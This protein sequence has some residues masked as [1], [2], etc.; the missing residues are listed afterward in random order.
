MNLELRDHVTSVAFHLSLSQRMVA[1]LVFLNEVCEH[2]LPLY[3]RDAGGPFTK[4]LEQWVSP[5]KSLI[6]R[7]L[8][9]HHFDKDH[10]GDRPDSGLRWHYSIT[11][12][13]ELVVGLLREAGIYTD[14]LRAMPGLR[15][16]RAG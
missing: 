12:A 7:G 3:G 10:A 14:V 15:L 1:T 9:V 13:G 5:V 4:G 6:E 11:T 16:Q 2:E 8:V